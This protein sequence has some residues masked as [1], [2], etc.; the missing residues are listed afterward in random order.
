MHFSG[1]AVE[2]APAASSGAAVEEAPQPEP[3]RQERPPQPEP[4]QPDG[5]WAR[6]AVKAEVREA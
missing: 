4:P 6:V 1:A 3:P 2:E 5:C